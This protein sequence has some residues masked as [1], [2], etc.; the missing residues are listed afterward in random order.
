MGVQDLTWFDFVARNGRVRPEA[1]ALV[2]EG[3]RITHGEALARA[4]AVAG[5]LAAAG[6]RAGDRIAVLAANRPEIMDVA[7]AAARLGAILV[8]VNWRLAADEVAFILRDAAPAAIVGEREHVPALRACLDALS[9]AAGCYLLDGAEAPFRPFSELAGGSPAAA[10]PAWIRADDP[11][12]IIHT[13]AVAGSPRGAVLS[14]AN[15]IAHNVQLAQGWSLGPG[16]VALGALPL[17]HIVGLGLAMAVQQAGGSCVLMRRFDGKA[18]ADAIAAQGVALLCEFAPMLSGILDAA[19]EGGQDLGSLRAVWGLDS[20]ETI[21]RFEAAC[22]EARFWAGYGQSETSGYVCFSPHRERPGSA[23]RAAPLA[24]VE[25]VDDDGRPVAAGEAGEIAVRGPLVFGGY[26]N[27]PDEADS[28][29]RDGWHRT[30]DMGRLD[31]DGY[32]FYAGRSP[33]KELIKSGGEN[34]YPAEVERALREHPGVEAAVVIGVADPQ[35]GEVVKAVCVRRPGETLEAAELIGFVGDRIARFKRPKHVSFVEALP[36][37][38]AGTVDRARV[39]AEH[40]A[41]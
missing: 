29:V 18:A 6:L 5:G 19:A 20:P 10:G 41:P 24:L 35:W 32:L 23:G 25:I 1:T 37:T 40:G 31:P 16:S 39:K 14:H 36:L 3:A 34:V 13:A 7:A 28:T 21:A 12:V 38:A 8:P 4:E 33:A 27:R 22:P 15:L 26:W 2:F 30:G 9:P 11:F 17:F